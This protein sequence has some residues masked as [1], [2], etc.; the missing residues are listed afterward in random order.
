MNYALEELSTMLRRLQNT[1]VDQYD[2]EIIMQMLSQ[3]NQMMENLDDDTR[4]KILRRNRLPL[5][6]YKKKQAIRLFIMRKCGASRLIWDGVPEYHCPWAGRRLRTFINKAP[7]G[8]VF[9]AR[10]FL[11]IHRIMI[12]WISGRCRCRPE[13]FR[14]RPEK[15]R[16]H[17]EYESQD[18][19]VWEY[20]RCQWDSCSDH[21]TFSRLPCIIP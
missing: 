5:K 7:G 13:P 4:K 1:G 18:C 20:S 21:T 12:K 10:C 14:D 9:L 15:E 3:V 2:K 17:E 11:H 19:S 8:I 6:L 16:R